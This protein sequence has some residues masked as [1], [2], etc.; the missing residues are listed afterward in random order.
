VFESTL[1]LIIVA[2]VSLLILY[3]LF[4]PSIRSSQGSLLKSN[5]H[6]AEVEE[7]REMAITS[8]RELEL[9]Y[10]MGKLSEEDYSELRGQYRRR[11]IALLKAADAGAEGIDSD[12]EA[13][14]QRL[15]RALAGNGSIAP[16]SGA[17]CMYC[18]RPVGSKDKYCPNCG[19]PLAVATSP[20][21]VKANPKSDIS[22]QLSTGSRSGVSTRAKVWLAGG[23]SLAVVFMVGVGSLYYISRGAQKEQQPIGQVI[24]QDY[25]AIAVDPNS[26]SVLYLAHGDGVHVSNDG[27]RS[28]NPLPDLKGDIISVLLDTPRDGAMI[29]IGRDGFVKRESTNSSWTAMEGNLPVNDVRVVTRHPDNSAVLY[30]YLVGN[31]LYLSQDGGA[32]WTLLSDKPLTADVTG[33][34]VMPGVID[35]IYLSASGG[36]VMASGDGGRTWESANGF[37]NGALPTN[38]LTSISGDPGSG[39]VFTSAAR[40]FKGALYVGSARGVFKSTDGGSSWLRLPLESDAAALTVGPPGSQQLYVVNRSGQIFYSRDGGVTWGGK[41]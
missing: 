34:T 16:K 10:Q 39:D 23:A 4:R 20:Q 24:A 22:E 5:G 35:L 18:E 14:V 21:I 9:E 26:P 33:I 7:E 32:N 40:N 12:I 8:L 13:E 30:A 2:A 27:G 25:H 38:N 19:K 15:R 28:W 6:T 1:F 41:E 31:G 11:A 3:P 37:V 17:V 29:A 36:G